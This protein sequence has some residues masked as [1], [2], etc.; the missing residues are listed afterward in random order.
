[1]QKDFTGI[2]V[3]GSGKLYYINKG[4]MQKDYTGTVTIDGVKYSVVKGIAAKK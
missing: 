3:T 2:Y 4:I 1:M